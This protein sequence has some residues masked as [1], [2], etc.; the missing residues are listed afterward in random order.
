MKDDFDFATVDF[1]TALSKAKGGPL[2]LLL[3]GSAS[4]LAKPK[5]KTVFLED[6]APEE[7]AKVQEP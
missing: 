1:A 2:N 5:T 6:L 4:E 3:M 7:I